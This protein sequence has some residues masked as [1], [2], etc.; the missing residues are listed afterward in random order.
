[1]LIRHFAAL[2]PLQV[3]VPPISLPT[4]PEPSRCSRRRSA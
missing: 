1:M 2:V 4:Y 3:L